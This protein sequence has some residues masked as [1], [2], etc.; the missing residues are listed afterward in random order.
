M[1]SE[2]ESSNVSEKF[3]KTEK[4]LLHVKAERH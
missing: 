2:C 1:E 4:V 3:V